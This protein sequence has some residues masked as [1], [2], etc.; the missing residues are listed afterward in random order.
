M[1]G[2][3]LTEYL[4]FIYGLSEGCTVYLTDCKEDLRLAKSTVWKAAQ[5]APQ[6]GFPMYFFCILRFY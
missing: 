5:K 3:R 6:E 4:R 2:T 1:G